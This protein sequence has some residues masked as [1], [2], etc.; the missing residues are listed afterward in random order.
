MAQTRPSKAH[1]A[2]GAVFRTGSHLI[3]A[4]ALEA[5]ITEA[6]SVAANAVPAASTRAWL[7]LGAVLPH[8]TGPTVTLPVFAH[9][10]VVTVR[11]TACLNI[12]CAPTEA[13]SAVAH[14]LL[15]QTIST[16]AN[17]VGG[18]AIIGLSASPPG[19][20]GKAVTHGMVGS[21]GKADA[22]PVAALRARGGTADT[23]VRRVTLAQT[24][25]KVTFAL[26]SAHSAT[27][28]R[29]WNPVAIITV[30]S[31]FAFANTIKGFLGSTFGIRSTC[32]VPATVLRTR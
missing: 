23:G 21:V 11:G 2:L 25:L 9:T 1:T 7:R 19:E 22:V 30:V 5:S 24:G 13:R 14:T 31:W 8:P 27:M 16:T 20:A 6:L 29:T 26:T 18:G 10:M 32:A 12:A 3:A 28:L 4:R 17:V 15:A